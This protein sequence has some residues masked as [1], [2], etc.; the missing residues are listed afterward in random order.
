[1][2]WT[3][4]KFLTNEGMFVYFWFWRERVFKWRGVHANQHRTWLLR[5]LLH[6]P[7]LLLLWKRYFYPHRALEKDRKCQFLRDSRSLFSH[8]W[9]LILILVP[10]SL[11]TFRNYLDFNSKTLSFLLK[12]DTTWKKVFTYVWAWHLFSV[13]LW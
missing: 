7:L 4:I 2:P 13:N 9:S 8:V 3:F 12:T 1:M 11:T 10:M 6:N 5:S